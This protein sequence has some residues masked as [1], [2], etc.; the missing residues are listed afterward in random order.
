V[1]LPVNLVAER[2]GAL[3]GQ[4]NGF[5]AG[6]HAALLI[7]ACLLVGGGAAIWRGASS[8]ASGVTGH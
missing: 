3:A 1:V 8:Q 2:I 5:M 4:A 7:S 6:T